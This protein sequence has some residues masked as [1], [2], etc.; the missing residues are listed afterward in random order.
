MVDF[1]GLGYLFS[2]FGGA[3]IGALASISATWLHARIQERKDRLR[4]VIDLALEDYKLS[5]QLASNSGQSYSATPISVFIHYHLGLHKL[6]EKGDLSES[7]YRKLMT[8]NRD[9]IRV[10]KVIDEEW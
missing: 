4:M 3:L 5:L 8:E 6:I 1:E 9:F 7:S 2:G 10:L